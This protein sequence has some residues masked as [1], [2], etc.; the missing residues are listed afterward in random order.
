MIASAL[1]FLAAAV[2]TVHYDCTITDI[3]AARWSGSEWKRSNPNFPGV[4]T[5]DWRFTI[6]TTSGKE[7]RATVTWDKDLANIAGSA[8]LL[9]LTDN[10]FAFVI[11]KSG[12]CMFGDHVCLATVQVA[13]VGKDSAH[14]AV[15]PAGLVADSDS[16][17]KDLFQV[18]LLGSCKRTEGAH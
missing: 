4:G 10:G 9:P 18:S 16:A 13:N 12:G 11:A 2:S 3:S 7:P 15:T 1:M 6:D 5:A 17:P 8:P 14:V